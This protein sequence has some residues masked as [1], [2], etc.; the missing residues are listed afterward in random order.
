MN[1]IVYISSVQCDDSTY[2]Y[3][4]KWLPQSSALTYLLPHMVTM[5]EGTPKV[6]SLKFVKY[7]TQETQFQVSLIG[8][9]TLHIRSPDLVIAEMK[10]CTPLSSISPTLPPTPTPSTI[11]LSSMNSAFYKILDSTYK[12]SHG[13]CLSLANFTFY[14]MHV[15]FKICW[16]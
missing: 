13:I 9:T 7:T 15:I 2:V 14:I 6:S 4:V 1:E 10:P 12:R 5:V 11:L 16:Y 3:F 8:V